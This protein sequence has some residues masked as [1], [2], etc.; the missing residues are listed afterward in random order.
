M[1]KYFVGGLWRSLYILYNQ[2]NLKLS[3]K[4]GNVAEEEEGGGKWKGEGED[5]EKGEKKKE[6]SN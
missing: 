4:L 6:S 5:E 2:Q 1:S 3:V